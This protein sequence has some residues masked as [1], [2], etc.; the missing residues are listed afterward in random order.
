V[1][2]LQFLVNLSQILS[3]LI[4]AIT[5]IYFVRQTK[6]TIQAAEETKSLRIA[7]IYRSINLQFDD[8]TS[9]LPPEVNDRPDLSTLKEIATREGFSPGE[10]ERAIWRYYDLARMEFELCRMGVL[11]DHMWQSWLRGIITS[12]TYPAFCD[13]WNKR[14]NTISS[15]EFRNS[16]FEAFLE[17]AHHNPKFL[18]D[19]CGTVKELMAWD[20]AKQMK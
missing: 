8:I 15:Y 14:K 17:L 16:A 1:E 20:N 13:V 18:L 12:F 7:E 11:T 9:H 10:A 19:Y 3:S 2:T 5:L 4:V 6:A